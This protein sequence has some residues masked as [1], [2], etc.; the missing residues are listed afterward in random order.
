MSILIP[1][2][3]YFF[4][5]NIVTTLRNVHVLLM[6]LLVMSVYYN[7]TAVAEKMHWD[8]LLW[9]AYMREPSDF[10]GRSSGPFRQAPLFGTIIGMLLP[11]HLYAFAKARAYMVKVLIFLSL[12]LGLAGLYFTY[13]RGSWIVGFMALATTALLGRRRYFGLTITTLAIAAVLSVFVLGIGQDRF[14]KKRMENVDTIET[15]IGLAVTALRVWR[16]E[17]LFGVGFFRY[18]SVMEEHTG[19]VTLPVYGTVRVDHIRNISL[20][21][22][23]LG[24]LAEDG[25]VGFTMQIGIYVLVFTGFWRRW[26][27]AGPDDEFSRLVLP[28]FAGIFVGYLVGGLAIDYRFFSFV[29]ALYFLAA[30]IQDGHDPERGRLTGDIAANGVN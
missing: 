21:D 7:I 22:I 19:P 6:F 8:W 20:H 4:A 10:L 15:R 12:N 13:T 17:P 26:R 29:G 14:M 2:A 9:P 28:V 30:G 25:L 27:K 1:Y 11:L 23:Y 3:A 24:P 18:R 5:K 16:S